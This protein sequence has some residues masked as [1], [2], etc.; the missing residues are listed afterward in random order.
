MKPLSFQVTVDCAEPHELAD[1]WAEAL[2]WQVEPSDESFIRRMV[3]EG[4]ATDGDTAMHRGVLVWKDGAAIRPGVAADGAVHDDRRV[5]FMRVPEPKTV[6]NR[7]H[8]DV[9]VG[10]DH[11]EA[12]HDRLAAMGATF[13]HRG[14]EGP[15]GW[16]TLHDPAGNEFCIH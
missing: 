16:I 1:W 4:H 9:H 11:V 2:G 5:L 14:N 13:S 3:A 6:K 10:Q 15:T 12:E 7:L 8:F